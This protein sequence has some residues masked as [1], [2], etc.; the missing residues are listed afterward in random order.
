MVAEELV[1]IEE[2]DKVRLILGAC[3]CI[4]GCGILSAEDDEA[5]E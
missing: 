2:S 3:G 5:S 4:T 1:I